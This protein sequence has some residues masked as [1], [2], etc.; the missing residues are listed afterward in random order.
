MT[1]LSVTNYNPYSFRN[2]VPVFRGNGTVSYNTQMQFTSQPDSFVSSK[3]TP[4]NNKKGISN[5]AIALGAIGV[6]GFGALAYVLTRGKVGQKQAQ[7]LAEHIEFKEAKNIEE[8]K[9]FAQEKLGLHLDDKLND[10][11]LINFIN[12]CVTN[13]HKK[14]N[15]KYKNLGFVDYNRTLHDNNLDIARGLL[16]GNKIG[17]NINPKY[18]ENIENR[19]TNIIDDFINEGSLLNKNGKFE[20]IAP[21]RKVNFSKDLEDFI[22]RYKSNPKALSIKEKINFD[23]LTGDLVEALKSKNPN[24]RKSSPFHVIYHEIGHCLHYLEGAKWVEVNITGIL[25]SE[26]QALFN[27]FKNK[28]THI[29]KQV[30]DYACT[31]P[32]EFVAE[33]F[34]KSLD[35][36]KFS[37]DVMTLYKKYGG[38]SL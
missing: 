21:V 1:D 37:G 19:I 13:F 30:S 23:I 7:Q 9:M 8:A 3:A 12:E 15:F 29:A 35:G 2:N 11:E 38:P 4:E 14:T 5:K 16:E 26:K 18:I 27:E 6:L 32:S 17:F 28:Y 34:A 25:S 33:V 20:F 36:Q 24:Y 31:S 10:V 22:T